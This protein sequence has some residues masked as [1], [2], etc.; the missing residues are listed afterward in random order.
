MLLFVLTCV[1]LA[2]LLGSLAWYKQ[3][4]AR[5]ERITVTAAAGRRKDFQAIEI[6]P[7]ADYCA[8]VKEHCDKRILLES[9]PRL[10]LEGCDRVGECECTYI[11]HND[12]RNHENRRN[13]YGSLSQGSFGLHDAN[14]RSG[15]DR[16]GSSEPEPNE[17]DFNE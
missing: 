4:S 5:L 14:K 11:N 7:G 1:L 6:K 15:F 17:I 9:S 10:P 16:R 8:A 13:P 2:F 12:R 3:R